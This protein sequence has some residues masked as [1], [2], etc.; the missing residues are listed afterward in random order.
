MTEPDPNR[1]V[2]RTVGAEDTT[3]PTSPPLRDLAPGSQVLGCGACTPGGAGHLFT[4]EIRT[5]HTGQEVFIPVCLNCCA[6]L[7]PLQEYH[8][9]EPG[10][11][12]PTPEP[13]PPQ[14]QKRLSA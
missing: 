5:T 14:P 3:P 10:R 2:R 1:S 12:K 9:E 11:Q 13:S 8:G 6:T 4:L 7:T